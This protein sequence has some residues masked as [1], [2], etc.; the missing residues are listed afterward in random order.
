MKNFSLALVL[1]GVSGLCADSFLHT[2]TYKVKQSKPVYENVT[3][4]TPQEICRE[5]KV[6]VD[7]PNGV[8]RNTFGVDTLIGA[9]AGVIIGNQIGGGSGNDVAKV[10]GGILGAATANRMRKPNT[11][12]KRYQTQTVCET[13]YESRNETRLTGYEN[14]FYINGQKHMKFSQHPLKKVHVNVSYSY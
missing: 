2:Q 7:V 12:E 5:V 13:V 8:D 11:Y 9:T 3:I 1:F 6:A 4:K 10:L 14:Y